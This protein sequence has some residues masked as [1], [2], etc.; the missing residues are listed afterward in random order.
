MVRSTQVD[1]RSIFGVVA[2]VAFAGLCGISV[3]L[4]DR[5]GEFEPD[6]ELYELFLIGLAC[7]RLIHLITYDKVLEPLRERLE[8]GTPDGLKRP[9]ADFMSCIWC[10][11]MWS[12]VVTVTV[13][14][15]GQWGRFAVLMV[16]VAGLGAL[17]QVISR[18][19]AGCAVDPGK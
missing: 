1:E 13:Y 15:L 11:G 7:L 10:T 9:L 6:L 18:A 3:W 19:I 16:A 4:I 17:L 8:G 2:M 14:M 12:A 5:F